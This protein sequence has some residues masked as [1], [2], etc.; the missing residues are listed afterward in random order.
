ATR[1]TARWLERATWVFVGLGVWLRVA[2]SLM[3]YPRWWDEAFLAVN[4]IR[5]GY[6]DLFW[7][8]DYNQVCPV[9][10]L[11]IGLTLVKLL[12]FYEWSLRLFPLAC[13]VPSVG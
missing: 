13:A 4:L 10:F 9:L 12:G 1:A 8:L 11:W 2:R 7:P 5:R 3:D 6:L